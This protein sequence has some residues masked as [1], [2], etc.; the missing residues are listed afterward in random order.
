MIMDLL[1]QA[2]IYVVIAYSH[3]LAEDVQR[4]G[5]YGLNHVLRSIMQI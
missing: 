4:G 1:L 3:L 5:E 2:A